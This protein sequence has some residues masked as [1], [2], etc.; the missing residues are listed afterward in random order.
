MDQQLV[1]IMSPYAGDIEKNK[2]F[3]AACCR[4]AIRQGY[5][6]IAPHLLYPQ[7]LNDDDLGEREIGLD[8]GLRL[9]THCA[10]AWCCGSR[11]S[12]GMARE[13]E[14]AHRLGI[15]VVHIEDVPPAEDHTTNLSEGGGLSAKEI[16][17]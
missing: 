3:A 10:L 5:T 13:I 8:L 16:K 6:P 7:I 15:P 14:A 11:I 4:Y 12:A 9:L 1:Y 2:A 17:A